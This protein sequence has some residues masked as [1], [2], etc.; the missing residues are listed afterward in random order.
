MTYYEDL[1]VY[2]YFDEEDVIST[3]TGGYIV[4]RPTYTRLNVGWLSDE[5]P[6]PRGTPPDGLLPAL[7]WLTEGQGVN[8]T[9]GWHWCE[10][11]AP[12]GEEVTGNGE[13]RVPGAPGVVYAAP[14]M[15]THYVAEHGYL[16]PA[17]FVTALLAYHGTGDDPALPSWVPADAERIL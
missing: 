1:S 8:L 14:V 11:C 2:E 6:F 10:L 12:K 15:I 5:Q 7:R 13:I 16:P 4:V 3:E 17:E 9:R